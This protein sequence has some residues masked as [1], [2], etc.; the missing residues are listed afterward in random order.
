MVLAGEAFPAKA[1]VTLDVGK[2]VYPTKVEVSDDKNFVTVTTPKLE[3]DGVCALY[4]H[5]PFFV[6]WGE[7]RLC[8]LD[9]HYAGTA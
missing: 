4:H 9:R 6:Q 8:V 5:A 2:K 7:N 1:K 3:I